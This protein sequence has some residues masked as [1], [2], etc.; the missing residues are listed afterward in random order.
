VSEARERWGPVI[1]LSTYR[2]PV[3]VQV[4]EVRGVWALHRCTRFDGT[5][6][7]HDWQITHIPSGLMLPMGSR[8][9]AAVRRAA[10]RRVFDALAVEMPR[11]Q[12]RAEPGDVAERATRVLRPVLARAGVAVQ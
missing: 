9:R 7:E 2:G 6:S 1:R 3:Y 10:V 5:V 4:R 8:R 11:W 12:A